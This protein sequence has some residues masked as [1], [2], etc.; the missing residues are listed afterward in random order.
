MPSSD[1][2]FPKD[3]ETAVAV[4]E[5]REVR[6]VG[7]AAHSI[8]VGGNAPPPPHPSWSDPPMSDNYYG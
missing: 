1:P 8:R 7:C 2:P 6:P 5:D 4:V 3:G